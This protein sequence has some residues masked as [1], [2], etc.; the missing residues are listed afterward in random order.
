MLNH[1]N[2]PTFLGKFDE[3][4]HPVLK[5]QHLLLLVGEALD[6]TFEDLLDAHHENLKAECVDQEELSDELHV[7]NN[8]LFLV[9]VLLLL[10]LLL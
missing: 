6:D 8:P 9:V 10:L 4:L 1:L 3:T 5:L 2:Y 7:A